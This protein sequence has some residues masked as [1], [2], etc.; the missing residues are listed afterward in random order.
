MLSISPPMSA[1]Q[2]D[3][4]IGLAR[5]DYYLE[6]GG[7]PPGFWHGRGAEKL[8]LN[9]IVEEGEFRNA[10]SGFDSEGNK[11]VQNAGEENRQAGWDLTFSAPKSVSTIWAIANDELQSQVQDAHFQA[12]VT[13]LE[14]IETATGYSRVGAEGKREAADLVFAL[15]EHGTSR[16]Q[17]PQLH[18][19]ALCLNIGVREDGSTGAIVSSEMFRHKMAAGA[20]YRTELA[21]SLEKLGFDIE[22]TKTW[23]E[24]ADVSKDL[25]AEFSTRRAEIL[26]HQDLYGSGSAKSA[27]VSAL[28]TRQQKECLPRAELFEKWRETGR[29]M[30][31]T[32][33]QISELQRDSPRHR[34]IPAEASVAVDDAIERILENQSHFAPRDLIR[35]AAEEGQGRGLSASDVLHAVAETLDS[36]SIAKLQMVRGEE[37]YT[38]IQ[39]LELERQL[40]ERIE[41]G[42]GIQTALSEEAI[43]TGLGKALDSFNHGLSDEQLLAVRHITLNED[44]VSCVYGMAGTGKSTM[45]FAAREAWEAKDYRVLGACLS[46]KAAQ[47]LEESSGIHS[48]TLHRTLSSLKNGSLELNGKTVVVLDEAGMV[49]TRQMEELIRRCDMAGARVVLVGDWKQLQAVEAGGPFKEIAEKIG[50]AELTDIRRQDEEWMREAVRL[51]ADGESKKALS[52]FAERDLL[53]VSKT[54]TDCISDL[55][56]D[57]KEHGAENPEHNLIL[58][59][60]NLEAADLNRRAQALRGEN[61]G[62]DNVAIPGGRLFDGDR[63]LFTKNNTVLG[64]TNGTLATVVAVDEPGNSFDAR[65]DGS[66]EIVSIPLE[67]Y[68]DLKLGYAVTTHKS[69]GT[70]VQNSYILAGGAMQDRELSYVQA[71]RARGDTRF[72]TDALEAGD[73][74][75][76]LERQMNQSRQKDLAISHL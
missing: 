75:I 58:A 14:Y 24:V 60:T 39:M 53:T 1:G 48:K 67:H 51:F 36:E 22:R 25:M 17:E 35:R 68:S 49:G 59:G 62:E 76:E 74:L 37:R 19:H 41:Q 73:D 23:F 18:H 10:F 44:R 6:N 72:Y 16:S 4:Y 47:G 40:M 5:E 9:G 43:A 27:A 21:H 54:R 12:V 30:G 50:Y 61:L 3:Y 34:D 2:G 20:L 31:F 70:T 52:L 8:G 11:L 71:S 42:K 28:E 38:T 32:A 69:Q 33:E 66:G 64:V 63:V 57:W 13:A 45:L 56:E 29:E 15:F 26:D 65:L 55:L 46:G 7:E